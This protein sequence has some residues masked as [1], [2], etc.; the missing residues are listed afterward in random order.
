MEHRPLAEGDEIA[1][2]EVRLRALHTPGHTPHHTSYAVVD[3]RAQQVVA[4]FS[5]GCVLV[6]A[7]GRTDLVSPDLT[8]DLTRAQYRSASRIAALPDSTA[9]APT[10]GAGS[11]CAASAAAADT[12]TTVS[13]E[14][15]RNPAFLAASEDE[16]VRTQLSGLPAYPSYYA[17]MAELNRAGGA[18]WEP[19]PPPA[20][21]PDQL[22]GLMA[23][24]TTVIDG[25][26]RQAFAAGHIPGT[27]NVELDPSFGT[28]VGWLV[29]FGSRL[30]FVLDATQ[31][32]LEAARQ[33]G[34][35]GIGTIDGV[36]SGG[37][38]AWA[39]SGRPLAAYPVTDVTGMHTAGRAGGVRLLDVRQQAEWDS[40]RVPGAVHIH[41]PEL[42][43]RLEELG[44]PGVRGVPGGPGVRGVPGGS[45][46]PVYVYCRTGHRAAMAASILDAAGLPAVLVDGGFP[47][48]VERG[49]PVEGGAG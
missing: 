9:V 2:G 17:H 49:L 45:V 23:A 40:G 35:I 20:L 19:R 42:P 31:D 15:T 30:A 47:D 22:E 7:C 14:R 16:F 27:V 32:P 43:G 29:P 12:W 1:V 44:R 13:R 41:V 37:V 34:R 4:V 24:G 26:P 21:S 25:R 8:E 3:P 5:G 38:E 6:G 10:H 48:W 18:S 33:C 36:L 11:F 46:E 39:A 28:Y